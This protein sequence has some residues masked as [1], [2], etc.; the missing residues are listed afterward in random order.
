MLRLLFFMAMV[1]HWVTCLWHLL[2]VLLSGAASPWSFDNLAETAEI[3][4][5]LNGYLNAFL[6]MIG[7]CMVAM[8]SCNI[9]H[10]GVT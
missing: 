5:F 3:T 7:K 1:A 4:S 2:Y 9:S 6:L 8:P 10:P